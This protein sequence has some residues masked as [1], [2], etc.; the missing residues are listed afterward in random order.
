MRAKY[1]KAKNTYTTEICRGCD[2]I[3]CSQGIGSLINQ[4]V[5][6][7]SQTNTEHTKTTTSVSDDN[8]SISNITK[9][10]TERT[11]NS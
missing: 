7:I 1:C 9:I 4:G 6:V 8:Q 5:N 2:N 3:E 10:D 11:L